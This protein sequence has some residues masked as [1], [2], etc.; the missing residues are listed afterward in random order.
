MNILCST[1]D[2]EF[3]CWWR[4]GDEKL[5]QFQVIHTH[6]ERIHGW[7]NPEGITL[8]AVHWPIPPPAFAMV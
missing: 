8:V 5:L 6:W 4:L 7:F 1:L 2:L 3:K